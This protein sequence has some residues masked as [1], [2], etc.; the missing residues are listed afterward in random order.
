MI[1]DNEIL[2][3]LNRVSIAIFDNAPACFPKLNLQQKGGKY[4]SVLHRDGSEARTKGKEKTIIERC[5]YFAKIYETDDYQPD[6]LAAFYV[7]QNGGKLDVLRTICESV[8]IEY[9]SQESAEHYE[10]K[11]E[12]EAE[13]ER[14]I[15][16]ARTALLFSE[17]GKATREYLKG[18]GYTSEQIV[19][20]GFGYINADVKNQLSK[21]FDLPAAFG[22]PSHPLLITWKRDGQAVGLKARAIDSE[23]TPKYIFCKGSFVAENLFL[24]D[25]IEFEK[26]AP[27]LV[28]LCEGEFDA[29]A[30]HAQGLNIVAS[31]GTLKEGQAR[32]L[33]QRIKAKTVC[34]IADNDN[35]ADT[36]DKDQAGNK[37]AAAAR[38]ILHEA[39][40]N[41]LRVSLPAETG[42]LDE[43][44]NA[45]RH[46]REDFD[47]L[48]RE[49]AS[50][51]EARILGRAAKKDYDNHALTFFTLK[52]DFFA[53]YNRLILKNAEI[54][55]FRHFC[56]PAD[57]CQGF[58]MI[59]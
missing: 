27:R 33:K 19:K 1:M 3:F 41:V 30:G 53:L 26:D 49:F 28:Y 6:N 43:Y 21:F 35:K 46:T 12:E 38:K 58:G 16:A 52:E 10:Q 20:C 4:V 23:T 7:K 31:A 47:A 37:E 17:E 51:T 54:A 5:T 13:K 29:L 32:I 50:V 39:G 34:I 18:R 2:E 45:Q 56:Q 15:N 36:A 8:N 11:K 57:R 22:A 55:I 44:F 25:E 24:Q 14:A 59:R 42:D 40:I 48:E 9:I